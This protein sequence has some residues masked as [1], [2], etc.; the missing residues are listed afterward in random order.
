MSPG[1]HQFPPTP[2]QT[3]MMQ[4]R[5]AKPWE[6]LFRVVNFTLILAS[7]GLAWWTFNKRLIPMQ[8]RSRQMAS[9]LQALSSQV[10]DM[11]RKWP[12]YE[13]DQVRTDYQEVR[14]QLF[15][16]ELELGRWVMRLEEQSGPLA[17]EINVQF[18]SPTTKT[19]EME[20]LAVI[21][22][23][24]TLVVRPTVGG[25]QTPYQ[26]MLRLGQQLGAEGKRADLAELTVNGG[27]LSITK[28]ILVFN[29]WAGEEK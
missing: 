10:D 20:K 4:S 14:N 26:R 8:Q 24:I 29:M 13:R 23:S 18:G 9:N 2:Q 15:A 7:L 19:N 21:P 28:G 16:D 1:I 11:S 5:K 3:A 22:A 6:V 17:L 27:P 25:T 12:K